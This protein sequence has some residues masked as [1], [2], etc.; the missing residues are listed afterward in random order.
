MRRT[1][2]GRSRE[3]DLVGRKPGQLSTGPNGIQL[4]EEASP[5]KSEEVQGLSGS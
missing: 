2:T 4:S 5:M 3:W 1:A